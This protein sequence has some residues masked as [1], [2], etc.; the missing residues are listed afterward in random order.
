MIVLNVCL[1]RFDAKKRT[2][3]TPPIRDVAATEVIEFGP[4]TLFS[5]RWLNDER[6]GSRPISPGT[7]EA[8]T[9]GP[10]FG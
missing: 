9:D 10:I 8:A 7:C 3:S 6:S 5:N 4:S 1:M 2:G